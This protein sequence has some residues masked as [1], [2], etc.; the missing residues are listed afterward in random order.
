MTLG[1]R[2][3]GAATGAMVATGAATAAAKCGDLSTDVSRGWLSNCAML[4]SNA[5]SE[6]D[7]VKAAGACDV[8]VKCIDRVRVAAREDAVVT[9]ALL[10]N[11]ALLLLFITV[12]VVVD[13]EAVLPTPCPCV[14]LTAPPAPAAAAA[15]ARAAAARAMGDGATAAAAATPPA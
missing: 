9:T 14:T 13:V 1:V 4:L 15:A 8:G 6:L 12:V 7:A 11:D 5:G 3:K 10:V 2:T